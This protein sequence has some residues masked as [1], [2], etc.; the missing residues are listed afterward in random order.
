MLKK[1]QENTLEQKGDYETQKDI[2][3]DN[4]VLLLNESIKN[5]SQPKS[6]TGN[7][8]LQDAMLNENLT[9]IITT[10]KEGGDDV[11]NLLIA[12]RGLEEIKTN[13]ALV[14]EDFDVMKAMETLRDKIKQQGF[15]IGEVESLDNIFEESKNE[16]Q[17]TMKKNVDELEDEKAISETEKFERYFDI[18]REIQKRQ[19]QITG[20]G[21]SFYGAVSEKISKP[22]LEFLSAKGEAVD[23]KMKD[24][25]FSLLRYI[26]KYGAGNKF[27]RGA[28]LSL[29]IAGSLGYIFKNEISEAAQYEREN[30]NINKHISINKLKLEN[31]EMYGLL[32]KQGFIKKAGFEIIEDDKAHENKIEKSNLSKILKEAL[33]KTKTS[34]ILNTEKYKKTDTPAKLREL[35]DLFNEKDD[36]PSDEIA[37]AVKYNDFLNDYTKEELTQKYGK[38]TAEKIYQEAGYV[39]S[40]S[41][42]N[43]FNFDIKNGEINVETLNSYVEGFQKASNFYKNSLE[44]TK[45]FSKDGKMHKSF[46]GLIE[47]NKALNNISN[48]LIIEETDEG[49]LIAAHMRKLAYENLKEFKRLEKDVLD[50]RLGEEKFL[51]PDIKDLSKILKGIV[52]HEIGADNAEKLISSWIKAD[53][54]GV[55]YYTNEIVKYLNKKIDGGKLSKA[56]QKLTEMLIRSNI[57]IKTEKGYLQNPEK[58][59]VLFTNINAYIHENQHYEFVKNDALLKHWIKEWNLTSPEWKGRFIKSFQYRN[60]SEKDFKTLTEQDFT[61]EEIKNNFRDNSEGGQTKPLDDHKYEFLQEF[62]AYSTDN[63]KIK[64]FNPDYEIE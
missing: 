19:R 2:K 53:D 1:G 38:E 59:Y 49:K 62:Q 35:Y 8:R 7:E 45:E 64:L 5:L 9:D 47:M 27:A 17:E 10:L 63:S 16:V 60:L 25:R 61:F 37:V 33:N 14:K 55:N 13:Y 6:V 3:K 44:L 54:G 31:P 15:D 46:N 34:N 20:E 4:T 50:V 48:T 11:V 36:Y 24:S 40:K 32:E 21:R 43:Y 52:E 28:S 51:F 58:P 26:G 12:Y 29:I 41:L 39:T 18:K 22:L 30:E 56:D 23:E 57:I 42:E